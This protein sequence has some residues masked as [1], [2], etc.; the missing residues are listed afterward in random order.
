M[1]GKPRIGLIVGDHAGIGPE[2]VQKTLAHCEGAYT[3]LVI[4][5]RSLYERT[6][7]GCVQPSNLS[8]IDVPAGPD[9]RPGAVTADSGRLILASMACAADLYRE[10]AVD[11]LILAPITKKALHAAG[12]PHDS[13]FTLFESLFNVPVVQSVIKCNDIYRATVVGHVPFVKILERL[14][15]EAITQTGRNLQAVMRRFHSPNL[16][17]AVAALNPHAGEDGLFGDEE[18]R[19]IAPAIDLLRKEGMD[20]IGPCPAD[21][22]FLKARGGEVGGIVYLYHDQGNIAM[23]SAFFGEGVLLY[24]GVPLPIASVGHGSAL[25]I[26]GQNR[27]DAGNLL[28]CA[29]ALTRLWEEEHP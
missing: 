22:V 26:A 3:P 27:A 5:N 10:G 8:F 21:T 1:A 17:M 19:V 12:S 18:A 14:S 13:E 15:T 29:R 6:A 7:T 9:I 25:D 23:K 2:I 20:V 24:T 28:A 4:G 11:M 16:R